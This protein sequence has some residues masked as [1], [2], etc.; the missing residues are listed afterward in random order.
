[1]PL[2]GWK[3][4]CAVLSLP[5]PTYPIPLEPEP[6]SASFNNP[7]YHLGLKISHPVSMAYDGYDLVI[8]G[9]KGKKGEAGKVSMF[10]LEDRQV[11]QKKKRKSDGKKDKESPP[12]TS[13]KSEHSYAEDAEEEE[14]DPRRLVHPPLTHIPTFLSSFD[15]PSYPISL[16]L[17]SSLLLCGCDDGIVRVR[18]RES[19]RSVL[20][21][22]VGAKILSLTSHTVIGKMSSS[23]SLSDLG[24]TTP[25]TPTTS[26]NPTTTS[27][28]LNGLGV[29]CGL[30][31]GKG[32]V[33]IDM[34]T[35]NVSTLFKATSC[36]KVWSV[37]GDEGSNLFVCGGS[38]RAIRLCDPRIKRTKKRNGCVVHCI[39][40]A[41]RSDVSFVYL[42]SFKLISAGA[43]GY[44][45]FYDVRASSTNDE[46]EMRTISS[47]NHSSD[48]ST[49][50]CK[51]IRNMRV[52]KHSPVIGGYMWGSRLFLLAGDGNIQMYEL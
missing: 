25:S 46:E 4:S 26:M 40:G 43:D 27:S 11:V 1:H 31:S 42:D 6:P 15:L 41:H 5:V 47:P 22:D 45:S 37:C 48:L 16:S 35:K 14:K 28:S 21:V 20:D 12:K 36:V 44:V 33:N 7:L 52:F 38:D 32:V 17:F 2:P 13:D 30:D 50:F 34:A 29:L 24:I 51:R 39:K 8:G 19:G 23:S 49:V 18:D 9:K 10:E 3:K